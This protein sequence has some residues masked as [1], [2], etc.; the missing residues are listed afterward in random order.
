VDRGSV[1]FD[2]IIARQVEPLD[3]ALNVS[4]RKKRANVCLKARRFRHCSSQPLDF[5]YAALAPQNSIRS[6]FRICEAKC[7]AT[8]LRLAEVHRDVHRFGVDADNISKVAG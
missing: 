3:H 2:F 1:R 8:S 5:T 7:G 4:I 6:R